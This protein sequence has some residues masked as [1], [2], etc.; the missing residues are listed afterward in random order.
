MVGLTP[1]L[2]SNDVTG[3]FPRTISENAALQAELARVKRAQEQRASEQEQ[4]QVST[5]KEV[6]QTFR[7]DLARVEN[8]RDD[9][10]TR[11]QAAVRES[12]ALKRVLQQEQ[13]FWRRFEQSKQ[14]EA[15]RLTQQLVEAKTEA[16]AHHET[17]KTLRRELRALQSRVDSAMRTS[18]AFDQRLQQVVGDKR[19]AVEEM[20][21][22]LAKMQ[23]KLQDKREEIKFLTDALVRLQQQHDEKQRELKQQQ[24]VAEPED[25]DMEASIQYVTAKKPSAAFATPI[26]STRHALAKYENKDRH[27][28]RPDEPMPSRNQQMS[29]P[30]IRRVRKR[31]IGL[32]L[33][34]YEEHSSLAAPSSAAA[35]LAGRIFKSKRG[36]HQ[37]SPRSSASSSPEV[38]PRTVTTTTTS[39]SSPSMYKRSPSLATTSPTTSSSHMSSNGSHGSLHS[40]RSRIGRGISSGHVAGKSSAGRRS[41]ARR[42]LSP[43]SSVNVNN[44]PLTASSTTRSAG[45][46]INSSNALGAASSRVERELIGLRR[47][48]DACMQQH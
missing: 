9:A 33:P 7:R 37:S 18:E 34:G 22:Q 46:T 11:E 42:P 6:E 41:P 2:V 35:G 40:V 15:E 44:I 4:R 26:K 20:D 23:I 43:L 12:D 19:A 32:T 8:D 14:L 24:R 27:Q 5:L 29:V 39:S 16:R 10:R 47:K 17:S 28:Q 21:A 36:E 25:Q 48:M 1:C 45:N 3:G 38:S 31:E 13:D 30:S